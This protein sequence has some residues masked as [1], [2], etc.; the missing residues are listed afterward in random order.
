MNDLVRHQEELQRNY[1]FWKA[2]P[3]LQQVYA[4]FYKRIISLIDLGIP[5]GIVEIGSGIGNLKAHLPQAITTDLFPNPCLNVLCDGY[6][7]P[8]RAGSI[9]HLVLFDVF[10]HLQAPNAFLREAR[11][12]LAPPGRL[13]LFEPYISWSSFPVYALAHHEPVAWRQP[14]LMSDQPPPSRTYYAAQGNAT[15]L[16]FRLEL[17]NWPA[18]WT[19]FHNERITCFHYL[20]SGGYSKRAMYPQRLLDRIQKID[21]LLSRWPALFAARCLI[22]LHPSFE[23]GSP[24]ARP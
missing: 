12:V 21:E 18:G 15:R 16:F 14:I 19:V 24:L 1:R 22:G 10:H 11:R 5:G 8:F 17:P 9:S 4:G 6:E 23:P 20:L 13:V 7:L 2:K 3:L